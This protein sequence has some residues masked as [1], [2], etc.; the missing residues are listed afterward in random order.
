VTR[1]INLTPS[2]ETQANFTTKPSLETSNIYNSLGAPH[3][4]LY[5]QRYAPDIHGNIFTYNPSSSIFE[6]SYFNGT[7]SHEQPSI[8]Y[9]EAPIESKM[10]ALVDKLSDP[11][12]VSSLTW[13]DVF[14][15]VKINEIGK[16]SYSDP[17]TFLNRLAAGW[18]NEVPIL[19]VLTRYT[20]KP[21]GIPDDV[22]IPDDNIIIKESDRI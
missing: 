10:V 14:R 5:E 19:N 3:F 21:T 4:G 2:F 9:R 11:S 1:T 15:R 18:R 7:Y 6:K 12:S 13:W 20:L 17:K 16:L 22:A 8:E